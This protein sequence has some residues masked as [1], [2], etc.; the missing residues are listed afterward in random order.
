MLLLVLTPDDPT[1]ETMRSIVTDAGGDA[2]S[3]KIKIGGE[4]Y[5]VTVMEDD[6]DDS[7]QLH[8]KEGDIVLHDFL[9]YGYG[10]KLAWAKVVE[11]AAAL[12]AWADVAREK[13]RCTT[14]VYIGANY[15]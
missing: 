15:W 11:R 1:R 4:N 13:Y 10:E 2:D 6:Y 5:T 14:Q 7:H 12:Q 3:P 8:A 9:T